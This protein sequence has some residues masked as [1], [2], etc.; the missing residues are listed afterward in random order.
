MN[1]SN[2]SLSFLGLNETEI[3]ILDV[4]SI[5]LNHQDIAH[6]A[7]IPRTTAAFITKNLMKKGLVLPVMHGKRFRYIALTEEQLSMR[8]EQMLGEMKSTA[9]ERKGVQIRLSKESQFSIHI[10]TKE[11]IQ[12]YL[13]IATANKDT[14]IKAIQGSKSWGSLLTKLSSDELIK[15]NQAVKD[16]KIIVDGI[17]GDNSYDDYREYLKME[18]GA[19]V[20][21]AAESLTGR[22]ADYTTVS[23]EFFDV[24]SEIWIFNTTVI[25]INWNEEIAV[26]ITNREIMTF[27]R[28]MFEFVKVGGKKV[29]HEATMR[30]VLA[31]K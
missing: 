31:V 11:V 4:L 15:F 28:D 19:N 1:W 10:G 12:A 25:I 9:R 2:K 22:M 24:Y 18:A 27:L 30:E 7:S 29:N 16:N 6:A 26:E 13:R 3:K 21:K 14:R 17:I 23:K 8:L 5:A 20:K